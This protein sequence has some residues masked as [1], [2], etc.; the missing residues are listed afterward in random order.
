MRYKVRQGSAGIRGTERGDERSERMEPE[1]N[2]YE[3]RILRS[4][5]SSSLIINGQQPSPESAMRIA[6]YFA[7]DKALRFGEGLIEYFLTG[8]IPRELD[9]RCQART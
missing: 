7:G 1:V 9:K 3:I 5:R 4:G 6:S 2:D 8:K